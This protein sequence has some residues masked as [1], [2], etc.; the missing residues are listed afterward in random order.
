MRRFDF[1]VET[2]E[3]DPPANGSGWG[4]KPHVWQM[5][6]NKAE[7]IVLHEYRGR[8]KEEAVEKAA[9]AAKKYIAERTV[10]DD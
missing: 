5:T 6:T 1:R 4:A 7:P 2:Y 10:E 9:R 8:S 3:I